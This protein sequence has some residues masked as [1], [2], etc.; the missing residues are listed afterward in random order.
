MLEPALPPA[1][2]RSEKRR[3]HLDE[4]FDLRQERFALLADEA[5]D[6]AGE[7]KMALELVRGGERDSE[8]PG[9]HRLRVSS[10][11]FRD[12]GRYRNRAPA[13][14]IDERSV[15]LGLTEHSGTISG[16]G[17]G[18]RALPH[19]EATVGKHCG[20]PKIPTLTAG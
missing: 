19:R 4:R 15:S 12:V 13:Q 16:H 5:F 17:E 3:Q 11:A 6:I 18:M 9:K 8:V 20:W 10:R 7:E 14:L 1:S 2:H